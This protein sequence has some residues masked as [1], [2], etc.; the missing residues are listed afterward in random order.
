MVEEINYIKKDVFSWSDFVKFIRA[1]KEGKWIYRGTSTSNGLQTSIERICKNWGILYEK[2]PEI[3]KRIVRDFQRKYPQSAPDHF[4]YKD[5]FWWLSLMRHHGAPTRLL[6]WT[7]SPYVAAHFAFEKM[8]LKKYDERHHVL[9][10]NREGTIWII[11]RK[12]LDDKSEKSIRSVFSKTK[13]N[14]DEFIQSLKDSQPSAFY[15]LYSEWGK[16]DGFVCVLNPWH[17]HERLA[18]QQGIFLCHVNITKSFVDNLKNMAGYEKNLIKVNLQ[19][20]TSDL[21]KAFDELY[22]MNITNTTLFPDL[23]GYART[24]NTRFKFFDRLTKKD[25]KKIECHTYVEVKENDIKTD[26]SA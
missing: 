18:I 9:P 2:L 12:W 10:K 15:Q 26:E 23:D 22:R 17:L 4:P 24:F 13:Q 19:M 25:E 3:E 16:E 21:E 6:D 20:D 7:Y 11:N 1:R 8:L 5:T 14:A